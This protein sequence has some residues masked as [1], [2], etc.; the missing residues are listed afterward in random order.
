MSDSLQ[1]RF[2]PSFLKYLKVYEEDPYSKVFAPLAE[3]YIKMKMYDEAFMILKKG[4]KRHPSYLMGHIILAQYYDAIEK[5][6]L[7][8]EALKPF[9]KKHLDN[10]LLQRLYGKICSHLGRYREA[11]ESYKFL[12][13]IN[14]KNSYYAE[15]VSSL[16]KL[17]ERETVEPSNQSPFIEE[18]WSEWDLLDKRKDSLVK[19]PFLEEEI[20]F[21]QKEYEVEESSDPVLTSTLIELYLAQGYDQKAKELIQKNLENSPDNTKL[22]KLLSE[23]E[24]KEKQKSHKSESEEKIRSIEKVLNNYLAKIKAKSGESFSA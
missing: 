2:T 19:D 4:I 9:V 18:D 10:I 13:F 16:E 8:Y 12:L 23:I 21:K 3:S 5:F 14:P 20:S 6:E 11:L 7:G 15:K 1:E 24:S 22:L 17:L